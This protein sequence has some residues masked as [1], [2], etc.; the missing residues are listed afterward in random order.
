MPRNKASPQ[1]P[2][3]KIRV[4][5]VDDDGMARTAW[6]KVLGKSS[7]IKVIGEATPREFIRS[8]RNIAE[9]EVIVGGFS[10]VERGLIRS[11]K[12]IKTWGSRPKIIVIGE[13]KEQVKEAYKAHADWAVASPFSEQD[14]I[15]WIRAMSDDAKRL[16]SEYLSELVAIQKDNNQEE[17]F[18]KLIQEMLQL[19]FH[20]DLINPEKMETSDLS[21]PIRHGRL[22]FRNQAKKENLAEKDGLLKFD[23]FWEDARQNHGAK[24]VTVDVYN[25]EV[26][27]SAIQSLGEYLTNLHGLFGLVIGRS[28][29]KASLY[30]LTVALFEN[31]K[32][33]I[34]PIS[35]SELKEMLEYKAGGVNP[36]CLL[37]DLYQQLIADT[38]N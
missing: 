9:P 2:H 30:P 32:K 5:L 37:Q 10:F 33:A 23:E 13:N 34:L 19:L 1:K 6:K 29:L 38:G 20:P 35:D 4:L 12:L 21:H 28:L 31:E 24:Y 8:I 11:A 3:G 18:I 25:S 7:Q 15:T 27:P 22:I 14:L 16:C 17:Q 36:V 26:I